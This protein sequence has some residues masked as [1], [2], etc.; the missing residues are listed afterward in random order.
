[1][2]KL[3]SAFLLA[4]MLLCSCNS[5][6][7]QKKTSDCSDLDNKQVQYTLYISS[8]DGNSSTV[9][10]VKE[11]V[12]L[13]NIS[14]KDFTFAS[15]NFFENPKADKQKEITFDGK[16]VVLPIQCSYTTSISG[17]EIGKKYS[18][19]KIDSYWNDDAKVSAE[20][21]QGTGQIVSY[22]NSKEKK[23]EGDITE[24]IAREKADS[25]IVEL[26]G[27]ET[28]K[29]YS[30]VTVTDLSKTTHQHNLGNGYNFIYRRYL[31][32]YKTGE[33]IMITISRR[34]TLYG[35]N[36][37]KMNLFD[38]AEE[39]IS[40]ADIEAAEKALRSSLNDHWNWSKNVTIKID[41]TGQYFINIVGTKDPDENG[42]CYE[43][44]DF[45]ININ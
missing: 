31:H 41:S 43:P 29:K 45:Y 16:T 7:E 40:K 34:G 30:N 24:D 38:G 11:N 25:L 3:L 6:P 12:K 20:F 5:Q 14:E 21:R 28:L 32:G 15:G 37:L 18:I 42:M 10:D 22:L 23:T 1:M 9:P 4:V 39:K 8:F 35:I 33:S 19:G 36:A 13:G 44:C 2:K 26:Y 27:R 17:S